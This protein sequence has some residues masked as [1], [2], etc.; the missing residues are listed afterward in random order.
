M[1]TLQGELRG[2]CVSGAELRPGIIGG[3]A[4]DKF[5]ALSFAGVG[6]WRER[7]LGVAVF[8]GSRGGR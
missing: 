5:D 8:G 7:G 6:G 3:F 2:C 4:V 1:S